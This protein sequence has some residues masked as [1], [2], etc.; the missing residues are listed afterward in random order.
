MVLIKMKDFSAKFT[1]DDLFE[2]VPGQDILHKGTNDNGERLFNLVAALNM[3]IVS[4]KFKH[5]K[6]G[7]ITWMKPGNSVGKQI[8]HVIVAK[9]WVRIIKFVRSYRGVN[10]DADHCPLIATIKM[11][12]IKSE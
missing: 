1:K 8:D 10:A 6:E 9:K 4:T 7:K 12:I 11:K 3:Y 5:V 2:T